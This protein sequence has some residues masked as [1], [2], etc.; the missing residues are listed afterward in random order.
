MQEKFDDVSKGDRPFAAD[1]NRL[2]STVERLDS[3]RGPAG[4]QMTDIGGVRGE[5]YKYPQPC[6]VRITDHIVPKSST[7]SSYAVSLQHDAQGNTGEFAYNAI[8][9]VWAEDERGWVDDPDE[10]GVEVVVMDDQIGWR[11]IIAQDIIPV[12]WN[13]QAQAYMPLEARETSM[14][15]VT[16]G[17]DA[18]GF[19]DGVAIYYNSDTALWVTGDPVYILDAG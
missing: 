17:P 15:M 8:R 12:I 5:A 19:Y 4:G 9:Q 3:N 1:Y 7:L 11:P 14:V 6:M 2:L 10:T 16:S 18:G 13:K